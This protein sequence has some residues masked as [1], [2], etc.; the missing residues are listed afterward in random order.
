MGVKTNNGLEFGKRKNGSESNGVS[1][2]MEEREK[3]DGGQDEQW[4]RIY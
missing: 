3:K 2:F 4:N 1:D